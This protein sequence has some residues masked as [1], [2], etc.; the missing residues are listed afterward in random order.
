MNFKEILEAMI[1]HNASDAFVAP[2]GALRARVCSE[3]CT[4]NKYLFTP[5]DIEKF[6]SEIAGDPGKETLR[7]DKSCEAATSLYPYQSMGESSSFVETLASDLGSPVRTARPQPTVTSFVD[8]L[9]SDLLH[10]HTQAP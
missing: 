4:I 9:E 10:Q 8:V 1:E 2:G 3:V 6:I 7:E 5:K